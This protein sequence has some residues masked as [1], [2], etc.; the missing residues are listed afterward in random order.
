MTELYWLTVIGNLNTFMWILL[1]PLGAALIILLISGIITYVED[2]EVTYLKMSL[3]K[4]L[5]IFVGLSLL[6]SFIPNKTELLTIYGVGTVIDYV[7]ENPS[8]KQLPDK[9][10]NMLNIV[11]DNY[12]EDLQKDKKTQSK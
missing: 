5:P 10:V 3:Y 2:D 9:M 12:L 11:A 6:H 1:V 4:I 8:V 7:Q